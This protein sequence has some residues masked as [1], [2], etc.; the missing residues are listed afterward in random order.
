[1]CDVDPIYRALGLGSIHP[2]SLCHFEETL[3]WCFVRFVIW[4][5]FFAD[6]VGVVCMRIWYSTTCLCHHP[7]QW[8]S[9]PLHLRISWHWGFIPNKVAIAWNSLMLQPLPSASFGNINIV[10]YD[11]RLVLHA[12]APLAKQ[13]PSPLFIIRFMLRLQ[14]MAITLKM[15]TSKSCNLTTQTTKD[16]P[17]YQ[18]TK[19]NGIRVYGSWGLMFF[20]C[21]MLLLCWCCLFL[22]LWM[23]GLG[24]QV[25]LRY[26]GNNWKCPY[27]KQDPTKNGMFFKVHYMICYCVSSHE[28]FFD[29]KD[30]N[31]KQH[32]GW[33]KAWIDLPNINVKKHGW[34]W[35]QKSKVKHT[36][37]LLFVFWWHHLRT[38]GSIKGGVINNCIRLVWLYLVMLH[39]PRGQL[40]CTFISNY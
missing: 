31:L 14:E 20:I 30:D 5:P 27:S 26:M 4:Q 33:K 8:S 12:V 37:R 10:G 39:M 24:V 7:L 1:M 34:C 11:P 19:V 3:L 28:K 15:T 23:L 2:T 29:A 25:R 21:H 13:R 9:L 35:D 6:M 22:W 17:K 16:E 40:T 32:H 38:H 18:Q 36:G